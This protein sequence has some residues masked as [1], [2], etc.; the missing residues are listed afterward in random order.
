MLH[1]F[2]LYKFTIDVDMYRTYYEV[3][4]VKPRGR[5][6]IMWKEVDEK[7]KKIWEIYILTGFI[8]NGEG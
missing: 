2:A 1:D 7:M 4:G 6:N 5:P 3:K 8:V